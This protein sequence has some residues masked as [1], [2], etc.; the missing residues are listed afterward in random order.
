MEFRLSKFVELITKVHHLDESYACVPE[1]RDFTKD[2]NGEIWR[3]S[4]FSGLGGVFETSYHSTTLQEVGILPT[5]V[6]FQP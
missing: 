5:L 1:M 4:K 6:Y 3:K 2:P